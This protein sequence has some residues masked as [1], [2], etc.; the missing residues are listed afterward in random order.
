MNKQRSIIAATAALAGALILGTTA[1]IAGPRMGYGG[2]IDARIAS[3]A[4]R[5]QLSDEQQQQLRSV[6]EAQQAERERLRADT[7][8]QVDDLLTD[9]QRALRDQAMEA[10]ME[11]RLKRMSARLDLDD[12]QLAEIR[13]LMQ[14]RLADPT[15]TREEMRERVGM[16]LTEEQQAR[17]SERRGGRFHRMRCDGHR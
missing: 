7:R 1:G 5:L 13:A 2:D 4:E 14:A 8:R 17:L 3:M 9:E 10:R 6:F 12:A 11:Q 15:L 16:I